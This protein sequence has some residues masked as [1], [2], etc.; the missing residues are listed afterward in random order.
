MIEGVNYAEFAPRP[1]LAGLIER[2]WTLV[3]EAGDLGGG[4]QPVLP[5][6]RPEL[7]LHFGTPFDRVDAIVGPHR[8]PGVLLAGQLTGRLLLRP[9]G[10][11]AVLGVRF[12]PFGAAALD[13]GALSAFSGLTPGVDEIAPP[14]ARALSALRDRTGDPA[15]AVP[16]VQDVLAR[17]ADEARIDA[18]VRQAVALIGR[19]R[20]LVTID[21]LAA[22]VSWTRRH[23][24]RRF[25]IDVGLTPKRLAR[26]ARF[27]RA[28]RVL[29]S[30]TSPRRGS[31]TAAA[32]GYADQAH[33]IRDFRDLAGCAP[34]DH[35]V[36]QAVL[37]GFFTERAEPRALRSP[38]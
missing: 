33:F 28:L 3:G 19:R 38:A 1:A 12:H 24:E 6:G 10:R 34:G 36:R 7:V 9:R 25:L 8:Q 16:L 27:Q 11:I 29:E 26:I 37:T 14:L 20:G 30:A 13:L 35:L 2:L 23:L 22:D 4:D 31:D 5:D 17:H 21:R 15:A 18:R 32:C